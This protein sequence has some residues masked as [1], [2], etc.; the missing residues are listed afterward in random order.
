M[1]TCSVV[2]QP[3][4]E[5][6]RLID[7]L[8]IHAPWAISKPI[9]IPVAVSV[10]ALFTL[11]TLLYYRL[12]KRVDR[13]LEAGPLQRSFRYFAAPEIFSLGDPAPTTTGI[14]ASLNFGSAQIQVTNG[15]VSSIVDLA[16]RRP[17][18]QTEIPPQ[19]I[20]D[21]IG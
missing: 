5:R 9:T 14:A 3:N 4:S 7:R 12:A 15:E 18:V 20:G 11:F 8:R 10:I 6:C 16:N 17:V 21:I 13:E 1:H 19:L 2:D